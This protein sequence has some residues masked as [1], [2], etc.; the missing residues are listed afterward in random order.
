MKVWV[1]LIL[2][3]VTFFLFKN[4]VVSFFEMRILRPTEV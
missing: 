2:S 4:A 3:S 1:E